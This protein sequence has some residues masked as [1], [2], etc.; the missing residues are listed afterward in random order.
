LLGEVLLITGI[1]DVVLLICQE[2]ILGLVV[3]GLIDEVVKVVLLLVGLLAG[4]DGL[5]AHA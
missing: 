3:E 2:S 5:H 4:S 1:Q